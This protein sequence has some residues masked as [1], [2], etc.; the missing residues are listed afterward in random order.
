MVGNSSGYSGEPIRNCRLK[1]TLRAHIASNPWKTVSSSIT[2]FH[3]RHCHM[4]I[5]Q[6]SPNLTNYRTDFSLHH[7]CHFV[8][9]VT[10]LF[11]GQSLN[12]A[13]ILSHWRVRISPSFTSLSEPWRQWSS[14]TFCSHGD[15]HETHNKWAL[16]QTSAT[17]VHHCSS[18]ISSWLSANTTATQTNER[19]SIKLTNFGNEFISCESGM[20]IEHRTT[21]LSRK[22]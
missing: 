13:G 14:W 19:S 6:T 10:W 7:N 11:I 17:R 8:K 5:W 9:K 21:R 22:M 20:T 15:K 2:M 1:T 18:H 16:R 3:C 12:R 4:P